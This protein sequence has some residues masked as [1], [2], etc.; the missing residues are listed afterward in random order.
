MV[1][2]YSDATKLKHAR[3]IAKEGKLFIS[4]RKQLVQGK[5]GGMVSQLYWL[6][7][8]ESFPRNILLG[9][10]TSINGLLT[11]VKQTAGHK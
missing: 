5:Y 1:A 7:Y 6:V 4:E 10:R 8:R 9:K 3:L 11:L 2:N